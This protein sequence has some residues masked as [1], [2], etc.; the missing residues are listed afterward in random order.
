VVHRVALRGMVSGQIAGKTLSSPQYDRDRSAAT[1]GTHPLGRCQ[2]IALDRTKKYVVTAPS[3]YVTVLADRHD[4]A[5]VAI[6]ATLGGEGSMEAVA[7]LPSLLQQSVVEQPLH[8]V[9]AVQPVGL[10]Q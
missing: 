7:V 3:T 5:Q 2:R 10:A 4:L 1:G 6:L 9:P 8:P